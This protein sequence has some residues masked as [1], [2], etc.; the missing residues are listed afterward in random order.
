MAWYPMPSVGYLDIPQSCH[1][2]WLWVSSP[3]VGRYL[4]QAAVLQ[5]IH[6]HVLFTDGNSKAAYSP[7]IVKYC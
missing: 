7:L 5:A 6:V 3:S 4:G 2:R 1:D